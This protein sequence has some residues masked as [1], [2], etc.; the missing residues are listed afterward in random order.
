MTLS[1][2]ALAASSG[3]LRRNCGGAARASARYFRAGASGAPGTGPWLP[4]LRA[5]AGR[6][7]RGARAGAQ[8]TPSALLTQEELARSGQ[9]VGFGFSAGGLLFP[10]YCGVIERLREA[11]AIGDRTP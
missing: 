5:T 11:G 1:P 9:T 2:A 4:L 3:A 10:Y 8:S 7:A 6:L